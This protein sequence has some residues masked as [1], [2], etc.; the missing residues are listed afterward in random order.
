LTGLPFETIKSLNGVLHLDKLDDT[1]AVI[2]AKAGS[3]ID[4]KTIALP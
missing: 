3:S 1:S 4:L 2:L